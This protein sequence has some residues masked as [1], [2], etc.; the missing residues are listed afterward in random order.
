[1]NK[2]L[3]YMIAKKKL[4]EDAIDYVDGLELFFDAT[5]E[6]VPEYAKV[7]IEGGRNVKCMRLVIELHAEWVRMGGK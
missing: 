3:E 2:F 4:I 1:M 5:V 6:E 7:L